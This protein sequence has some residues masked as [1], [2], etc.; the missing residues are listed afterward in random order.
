MYKPYLHSKFK[1]IVDCFGTSISVSDQIARIN[2]FQP[3]MPLLGSTDLNNP[4]V[5]FCYYEDWGRPEKSLEST[6]QFR[7]SPKHCWF[8]IQVASGNRTIV[9]QFDLK[10]RN[11]IGTT[12]MDPELSLVMANQALARP[13]ALVLDPFV[14]TGSFLFTCSHFGAYSLGADIDGR[15]IRG[16]GNPTTSAFFFGFLF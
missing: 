4:E 11:Y 6:G 8:G 13:G 12:T 15:Q 9:S 3:S 5:T 7:T 10:K 2:Q 1:F 14:G 16:T